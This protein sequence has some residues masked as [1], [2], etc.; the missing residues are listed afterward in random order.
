MN[1]KLHNDSNKLVKYIRK[2][3]QARKEASPS[4]MTKILDLQHNN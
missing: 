2:K 4:Y 1:Q 3:L